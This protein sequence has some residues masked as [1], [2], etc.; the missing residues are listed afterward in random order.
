MDFWETKKIQILLFYNVSC[1]KPNIKHLSNIELLHELPF[2][3]ELSVVKISK[4]F[5]RYARS[6][7]VEILDSKD[8]LGQS[9]TSNYSI[10]DLL[11]DLLNEMKGFKYQ[12]TVAVLLSKHK[13][14]GEIEYAPVYFNFA[15]KTI[16]NSD[17][18]ML[19]KSFQEILH[20]IDN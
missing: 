20:R 18:Y 7:K 10:K 3:D 4:A 8:P 17:K 11:K 5:K 15:T 16:I 2:C 6:Y 9:K 13:I 1:K 12:I 19:D 14:N